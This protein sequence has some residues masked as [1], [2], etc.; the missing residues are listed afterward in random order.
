M[1]DTNSDNAEA[2]KHSPDAAGA[3]SIWSIGIYSGPTPLQLAP[4]PGA[5]NPVLSA[6]D[7]TD[8]PAR[9]VADPFMLPVNGL[10][11]MFFEVLNNQNDRGEIGLATSHDGLAWQYQR[12]VLAEPFHLSY[13]C[14]FR[15]NQDFYM[16]PET[17]G[18]GA[19]R[20]YRAAS[21]PAKWEHVT[22]LISG[23]HADPSLFSYGG[24]WWLF[25]CPNPHQHDTL[26]L[27]ST[28]SFPAA[29]PAS[30]GP[31]SATGSTSVGPA[32]T[33]G[34]TSLDSTSAGPA[35][36]WTEH[37]AS[38]LIVA[39]P[40]MARPGGRVLA[41]DG[42]LLRFTQDCFPIYGAQVRAFAI[43]ELTSTTYKECE[44]PESPV[45]PAGGSGW[46]ATGMHHVDAHRLQDESWLACVDGQM[47]F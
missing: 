7:V 24:R 27:Y 8:V 38:P 18:A 2:S 46:N 3:P 41:C 15:W 43:T 6:A 19:V 35:S 17:L 36:T 21:F 11:H 4:A 1:P 12:I 20:L 42:K 44:V 29:S 30:A 16:V 31:A 5:R 32:S 40:R 23:T 13:P 47:H 28:D 39:N 37:P 33:A 14:V 25:T 45:L 26:A 10:W 9:F 34:S 22:D